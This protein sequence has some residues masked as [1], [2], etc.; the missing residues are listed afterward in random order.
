ML[1]EL[2]AFE[3]AEGS[4]RKWNVT[5]EARARWLGSQ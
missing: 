1:P 2:N 3:I 5:L 4:D